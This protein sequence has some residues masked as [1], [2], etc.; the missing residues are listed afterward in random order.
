MPDGRG[1]L[2]ARGNDRAT[3]LSDGVLVLGV[4]ARQVVASSMFL[5]LA[6]ILGGG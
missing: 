5:L 2:G 4:V 1:R 3:G 6:N